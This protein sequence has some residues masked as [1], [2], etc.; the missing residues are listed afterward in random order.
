MATRGPTLGQV[1]VAVAFAFSCFGLLLFLWSAFG[2]PIPLKPEGYRFKVPFDE[3]TQL[4][5]ESDVRIANVSVGKVKKI[6][7]ADEGENRDLAVATLEVDNRYAPI[8]ENTRAILR[9]K[10]LLGETYVELTQGDKNGRKLEEDGTLAEA[11]VSDAVQLDE[12]FR[13]FDEP[14]RAA[15]QTWMQQAAIAFQGRGAD[16]S[17]AIANLEPFAEDANRLLRVLDTQEGA[18]KQ[19]VNNT[20][21]V[22]EALSERQGQLRGLIQNAGAVFATTARRNQDLR[23][24]FVALPTF[25]DESRLTLNRLDTFAADT[26]PLVDQLHPAARELSGVLRQTARV[27]PDFRGF[28]VGFRK[29]AKRGRNAFPALQALLSTDL[30]PLF[31]QL[32]PFL[33]Q[34]TP[35]VTALERHKPDVTGFLGNVTAATQAFNAGTETGDEF[36]HYLRTAATLSPEAFA[37]FPNRLTTGRSNPYVEP[38]GA[39]D[40]ASGLQSF[41]IDAPCGSDPDRETANLTPYAALPA[42]QQTTFEDR[43]TPGDPA[44][45]ADLYDRLIKFG[46]NDTLSSATTAAPACVNQGPQPSIGNVSESTN[47]LHVYPNP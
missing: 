1:A 5:V 34:L 15:F 33:R 32:T 20:G 6:E 13:T 35:I 22:F 4:A 9:Q 46:F 30:P 26:D 27:A 12:I 14:T 10:T 29:L 44:G 41:A 42:A 2:G 31:S 11:Q 37:V 38:G 19:F 7:L 8:P 23:E 36:T 40:V 25:L 24:T 43:F 47:Y 21:V 39:L 17:A 3:A 45:A 18:V 28:F 16:V